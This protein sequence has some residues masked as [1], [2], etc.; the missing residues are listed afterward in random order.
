[1]A[2]N[3]S[4]DHSQIQR[5]S[6]SPIDETQYASYATSAPDRR[7][8]V[9]GFLG[10][11]P[12]GNPPATP[13]YRR[14]A[15]ASQE[16]VT[17]AGM[18]PDYRSEYNVSRERVGGMSEA[19]TSRAH[20]ADPESYD[21]DRKEYPREK[22]T[23]RDNDSHADDERDGHSQY[24]TVNNSNQKSVHYPD[25]DGRGRLHNA[26]PRSQRFPRGSDSPTGIGGRPMPKRSSSV[27][28]SNDGDD[29]DEMYNWSDEEDLVDQEAKFEKLTGRNQKKRG[30]GFIR[31]TTFFFS[32]LIGSTLLS[33]A[34]AAAGVLVHIMW[35]KPHWSEHRK[36]VTDN[37]EAWLFWAAANVLVSWWLASIIDVLPHIF[38]FLVN[39]VWGTISE[40]LKSKL[41]LYQTGKAWI[42]PLFY[43]AC[44]WVSWAILFEG[45][46]DLYDGKNESQS[47]ASYT[48]RVYQVIRFLF[49]L[50]FVICL[51]KMLI[52]M[53]AFSF[54][55]T[56]YQERIDVVKKATKVLDHL[57]DYKPAKRRTPAGSGTHLPLGKPRNI[58]SSY[59]NSGEFT[60]EPGILEEGIGR[61]SPLG[62]ERGH[63]RTSSSPPPISPPKRSSKGWFGSFGKGP[64]TRG[65]PVRKDSNIPLQTSPSHAYPPNGSGSGS[66]YQTPRDGSASGRHTPRPGGGSHENESGE[67]VFVQAA[68]A[69]K[70]VVLHDARGIR[71]DD[72]DENEDGLVWGLNSAHEAKK[73]ARN[74][75]YA[76]RSDRRRTY[77]IPSDFDPAYP[78]PG[79]ARDAFRVFDNDDN[80]DI[81]RAE[82]KTAVLKVYKERRFLAKS[83]RDV[84]AAVNTLDTIMLTGFL[85]I[86]IFITLP[87]F[88]VS[89][90]SSFSSIYTVFI[91]A[92]FIFK[93]AASN[94]F[95]S[96]M[97]LFVTQ[98][99][100]FN[101]LLPFDTG[102]RCFIDNENLVVRKMGLFATTFIRADGSQTYYFN[103]MLL[104]K[105]INNARRS[106]TMAENL[107]MQVSWRTP[108]WKL[109]KL[110]KRMNE[111]IDSDEKRW[112]KSGTSVSFSKIDFQ[113]ALTVTIG[114]GH[115]GT[116]QD[117]TM[118]LARKTA[119]H[120]AVQ[121]FCR[122]L[123]I[124]CSESPQPIIFMKPHSTMPYESTSEDRALEPP[125]TPATPHS[126][127]PQTPATPTPA[128]PHPET[129]HPMLGFLPPQG[130][131]QLRIR[132]SNKKKLMGA[133]EADG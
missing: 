107:E 90:S 46:F 44:S 68:K 69:L 55:R 56:A 10:I 96:I 89:I 118:R 21:G 14:V 6:P 115:N 7:Q 5:R 98:Y 72:A 106:A 42:K 114:I 40:S 125:A 64:A 24:A 83:L 62:D 122:Q 33:G 48:P 133:A 11:D 128:D 63:A 71:G 50:T 119:F 131:N 80:G 120:A 19:G 36:Y 3:D 20:L 54:H 27:A 17:R 41:E 97:F 13:P 91:A 130:K 99:A 61:D 22:E 104:T 112:F 85:I 18:P 2:A 77:L 43:A 52:Q 102:D 66:G 4:P 35:L 103:S 113:R 101:F 94:A 16:A 124:T 129:S 45:V 123:E 121:Y 81:T 38:T 111:W 82:I 29:D 67:A 100:A 109:D 76:F 126:A 86:L 132:K 79:E 88:G 87:I 34:L 59:R 39:I 92:S 8:D 32:T 110:E 25:A 73:L 75:Y 23:D 49:F 127:M 51:E 117:W 15:S 37:I 57:K 93:N 108:Q 70:T 116:W 28:S 9:A 12:M 31:I 78:T 60:S 74:L 53:I 1:M 26:T 30:W 95:D 65:R 84:S 58:F 105:F 47:R